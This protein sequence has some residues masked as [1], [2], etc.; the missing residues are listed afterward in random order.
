MATYFIPGEEEEDLAYTATGL[1]NGC[2]S[3]ELE[4]FTGNST[5]PIFLATSKLFMFDVNAV[6]LPWAVG[7]SDIIV[8]NLTKQTPNRC[9]R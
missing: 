7:S 9:N 1:C 5:T 4:E 2:S 6:Q 8:P 3:S